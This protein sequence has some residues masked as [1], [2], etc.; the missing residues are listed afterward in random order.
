MGGRTRG[1]DG[2]SGARRTSGLVDCLFRQM[3]ALL[4]ESK[5]RILHNIGTSA[6]PL[7]PFGWK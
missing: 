2:G 5:R 4:I 7:P 3:H 1:T 6:V